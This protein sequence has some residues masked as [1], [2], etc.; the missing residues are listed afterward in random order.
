M[1]KKKKSKY[2]NMKKILMW[3]PIGL[4]LLSACTSG[5]KAPEAKKNPPSL[6]MMNRMVLQRSKN[7]IQRKDPTVMPAFEALTAQADKMLGEGLYSVMD[8]QQ[9]P[10]SGDKHDYMSVEPYWWPDPSKPDG[11]P[12]IRK[13]GDINPEFHACTDYMELEKMTSAVKTLGLAYFF[14][15]DGK[16]AAHAAKLLKVWFLDEA[17]RMNPNLNYGQGIPGICEGRSIGIIDT[18]SLAD[19][20]DGVIL[21]QES[22]DWTDAD[23][24]A[25]KQ[26][27]SDF[28]NWLLTSEYG[29]QEDEY[30]NNHATFFDVQTCVYS[31]FT[32]KQADVR[33]RL[34]KITRSRLDSQIE[35]DGSQPFE[36]D[37]TRPWHYSVFNLSAFVKLGLLGERVGVN[38]WEHV[39]PKGASLQKMIEWFFPYVSGE[40]TFEK[41]ELGGDLEVDELG[42]VLMKT[43]DRFGVGNYRRQLENLKTLSGG[44]YDVST[45]LCVLTH[46]IL[47]GP[48]TSDADLFDAL[49]LD[50]K[51]LEKVKADVERGDYEA[52]KH[53][54]VIHL[55][56]REKPVW[57][58][59]WRD[60]DKA[61]SRKADFDCTEADKVASNLLVACGEYN[62]FGDTIDWSVNASALKYVEWT[63]QLSRHSYW[64]TLGRAYWATGDEKYAKAFVRQ[65]TS[66]VKFNTLHDFADNIPYSRW[67]TIETGI[68]TLGAW[69]SSFMYFLGSP[70]FDDESVILMVKSFYEHALHL[71][72]FPQG[73][74]WLTMEMNGLFHTGVLFPE[75]RDAA[76]WRDFA[77]TKM[78]EEEKNQFYP[79]GAQVELAPSYQGVSMGS[80]MGI[81]KIGTLNGYA[82]PGDYADRLE[83]A[84]GCY[85]N[86]M[87]PDG[88]VPALNDSFWDNRRGSLAEGFKYMPHRTDFQYAATEGKEGTEPTFTSV[89]MPWSG[90]YVMRSGW[91][92]DAMYA[93]YEVGPYSPAH[94][95]EDKLSFILHA[96]G[97]TLLTESAKY[98][99]DTSEWRKYVLSARSH[100]VTRIDGM[101]QNRNARRN[102]DLIRHSRKPMENR[103]ITNEDFDFGEGWY[104][105]GFG[106]RLDT[107]VTQYRALVF[108]KNKYW[109][110][111]DVFTPTDSAEHTYA[112]WF[113]F[114]TTEH[115]V[116]A[117]PFAVQSTEKDDANLAI[118]PLN[119]GSS[120]KV[121]TGQEQPEVQG[122]ASDAIGFGAFEDFECRPIA[123]PEFTRTCSG[124]L[125]EPYL[126]YPLR[127][128]ETLPVKEVKSSDINHYEIVY[129]DGT[130]DK[131]TLTI[132]GNSLKTLDIVV[133]NEGEEKKITIIN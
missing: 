42:D 1:D 7:A 128:G 62:Q 33:R 86:L 79:D 27:F 47:D 125:V 108:V 10:P 126:F 75:F 29:K 93:H 40:K 73:N 97:N 95:H 59:N 89:W 112:S 16:Y 129:A 54:F 104:N 68:R 69:P 109:L 11:L 105:E 65:M 2:C 124:Q 119:E 91:D 21:L 34:D 76:D 45:A 37:R 50:Y 61:E 23:N 115:E 85:L 52:A 80:M 133:T 98:E 48:V 83:N 4:I 118:V 41:Q 32:G 24:E 8:K 57:N 88:R 6:I 60:Y 14:T 117:H 36:L 66:W 20:L 113:H 101:D 25:L 44:K 49:D 123:T 120:V 100:N 28:N 116:T 39:T 55:K 122:W 38:L 84:Y 74:N 51:G 30:F 102:E 72:A 67:R 35:A 87:M 110:M 46:P 82:L 78:Y 107:T 131:V 94:Q 130:S 22:K 58:I 127:K 71:R 121:I 15:E 132:E 77:S 43:A 81:Y 9:T 26:W 18:R 31:L 5:Q 13:D 17:T 90:W 96:Y 103:W 70:S 99:Y 92:A 19:M 3:L 64:T 12:Y 63:W 53:D 106:A 114:D 56:T 111:F